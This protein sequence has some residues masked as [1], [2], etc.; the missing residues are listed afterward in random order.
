MHTQACIGLHLLLLDNYL[1]ALN[2]FVYQ[3][4][5]FFIQRFL[6]FFYFLNKKR[7]L[8]LFILW[9]NVF[10]IQTYGFRDK[11]L[12]QCE[13]E[14]RH[15][16]PTIGDNVRAADFYFKKVFRFLKITQLD[17]LVYQVFTFYSQ[18]FQIIIYENQFRRS[19]Q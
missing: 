12:P 13:R 10:Y 14:S 19:S 9:V 4:V 17:F 5:T 7:I 11:L 2:K 15:L 16:A 18:M 1:L 8:T 3:S 6:K